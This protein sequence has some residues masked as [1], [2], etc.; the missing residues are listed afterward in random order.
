MYHLHHHYYLNFS[1]LHF[2]HSPPYI[3]TPFT[4]SPDH[5]TEKP[6]VVPPTPPL[7][8]VTTVH[9]FTMVHHHL[10][11]HLS[12]LFYTSSLLHN[13]TNSSLM[14]SLTNATTKMPLLLSSSQRRAL[15]LS[16]TGEDGCLMKKENELGR[17]LKRGELS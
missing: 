11:F 10:Y 16:T 2:S 8:L 3:T 7:V 5:H 17:K 12:P 13:Y 9:S 14:I 15:P 4:P 1:P 6:P